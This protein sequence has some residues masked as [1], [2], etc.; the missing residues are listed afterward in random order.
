MRWSVLLALALLLSPAARPPS[1]AAV[2]VPRPEGRDG[3]PK[4]LATEGLAT[5]GALAKESD[6]LS[7]EEQVSRDPYDYA[8][9]ADLVAAYRGAGDHASAYYHAAWLSWLASR[10]Y[11]ESQAGSLSLRDR[12]LRDR[13]ARMGTK[14]PVAA[15]IAAVKAKRLLQATCLN[16]A[17]AQQTPRLRAEISDLLAQAERADSET[18]KA[19]PVATIAVAHLCLAL[20]DVL[21][22]EDA[23]ESGRLR[24]QVLRKAASQATAVVTWLPKSSGAHRTLAI[25]RAR[26]ADLPAGRQAGLDNRAELW[27][28]ATAEGARAQELD[29]AD[30]ALAE[31]LWVL[32]LRAG[33]WAEARKWQGEALG[34]GVGECAN[35]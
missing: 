5:S 18:G 28:L 1:A 7:R 3:G 12:G 25:V 21:A 11:A 16:G 15:A 34:K 35:K 23:P 24:S 8:A 6:M 30:P 22:L 17:I 26:L 32:H 33:H 14:G 4:G 9:R 10:E 19:D 20:D 31:V 13:A 29:P 2:A 27:N